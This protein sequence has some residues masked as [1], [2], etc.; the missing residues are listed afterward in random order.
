MS[1]KKSLGSRSPQNHAPLSPQASPAGV[2]GQARHPRLGPHHNSPSPASR[3]H[4]FHSTYQNPTGS[5]RSFPTNLS[6][7]HQTSPTHPVRGRQIV[8]VKAQTVNM[9]G[10]EFHILCP[11]QIV[12]PAMASKGQPETT[13]VDEC[14][15]VA[16]SL[17]F[18]KQTM[19]ADTCSPLQ[20]GLPHSLC[21]ASRK[22]SRSTALPT[23]LPARQS[24]TPACLLVD[25]FH[26]PSR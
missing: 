19:G 4:A 16:A 5:Q 23:C 15:H 6:S 14:G 20:P 18:Q 1:H 3:G 2:V 10:F 9:L 17:H 22:H 21:S 11:S 13:W 24:S 7:W 8:P 25:T 26:G 12:H